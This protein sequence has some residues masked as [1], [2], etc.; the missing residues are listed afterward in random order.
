MRLVIATPDGNRRQVVDLAVT[1]PSPWVND[2]LVTGFP[3]GSTLV[4][5]LV[6]NGT[7][8]QTI[9]GDKIPPD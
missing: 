8:I 3:G 5:E 2:V 6:D 9:S 4:G 1:A 7:V